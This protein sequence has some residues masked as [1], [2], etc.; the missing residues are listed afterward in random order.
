MQNRVESAEKQE[1]FYIDVSADAG[2][3]RAQIILVESSFYAALANDIFQVLSQR[4]RALVFQIPAIDY[5][6]WREL[7]QALLLKLTELQIRQ[8]AFIALGAAGS[9]LQ[10]LCL[11]ESKVVR[12]AVFVDA[13]TRPHPNRWIKL[14]DRLERNLPMGLPF[15]GDFKGFDGRSLLQ[16]IRC[17]SLVLSTPHADSYLKEQAKLMCLHLP[18]SWYFDLSSDYSAERI[19]DLVLEFEQVPAKCPQKNLSY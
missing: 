17:P 14:V 18:T 9:I 10:N 8:A 11:V 7:T 16:R 6:N 19:M 5:N 4:T 3:G 13:A 15:R 1:L 12:S 2:R